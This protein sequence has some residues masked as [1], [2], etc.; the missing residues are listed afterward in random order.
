MS[1]WQSNIK[2]SEWRVVK[3]NHDFDRDGDFVDHVYAL[4]AKIAAEEWETF[5]TIDCS[6]WHGEGIAMH[7]VEMHNSCLK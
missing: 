5:G 2:Y 4:Q 3:T 1:D 6:L 7:I